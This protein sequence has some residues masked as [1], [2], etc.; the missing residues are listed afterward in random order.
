MG[1][2][3]VKVET[4]SGYRADERL[5]SFHIG[6]KALKVEEVLDR[7]Y[8]EAEDYFKSRGIASILNAPGCSSVRQASRYGT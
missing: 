2:T 3:L 6:T 8:G 4:Y 5:L 7:W 1:K